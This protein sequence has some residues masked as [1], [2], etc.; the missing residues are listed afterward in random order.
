MNELERL[1]GLQDEEKEESYTDQMKETLNQKKELTKRLSE[2]IKH[3]RGK[4]RRVRLTNVL[5]LH[6]FRDEDGN[7]TL[8]SGITWWT[9]K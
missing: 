8:P 4:P 6:K 1:K 5:D 3:H 9:L 7:L 2:T